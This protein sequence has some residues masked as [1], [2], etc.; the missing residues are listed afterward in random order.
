ML[1]RC[2]IGTLRLRSATSAINPAKQNKSEISENDDD[3]KKT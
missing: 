1:Q 2:S 3:A